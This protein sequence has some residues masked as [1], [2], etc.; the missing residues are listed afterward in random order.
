MIANTIMMII[1][2]MNIKLMMVLIAIC[3]ISLLL[4]NMQRC[5][6]AAGGRWCHC[7]QRPSPPAGCQRASGRESRGGAANPVRKVELYGRHS[8][9]ARRTKDAESGAREFCSGYMIL[10][11][12]RFK[13][14]TVF[15]R[16]RTCAHR[17][18]HTGNECPST[19]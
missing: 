6:F 8:F 3:S 9:L 14:Q 10:F 15:Y 17:R 12:R 5:T 16:R 18:V 7:L 4:R 1:K 13:H 11:I 19:Q 2:V